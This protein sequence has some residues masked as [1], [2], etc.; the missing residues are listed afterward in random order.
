MEF[1]T[2]TLQLQYCYSPKQMLYVMEFINQNL[3][4][5]DL[6]QLLLKFKQFLDGYIL[7]LNVRES[8]LDL[9]FKVQFKSQVIEEELKQFLKILPLQQN[10]EQ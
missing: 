1:I 5:L 8:S 3:Y 6:L 10:E 7:L 2:N 9:Q 4:S